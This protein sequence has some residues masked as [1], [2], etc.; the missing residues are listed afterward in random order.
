MSERKCPVCGRP[1]GSFTQ[2]LL[3]AYS[4]RD[5]LAARVAE[6]EADCE[7]LRVQ[8]AACGVAA[9]ENAD[10]RLSKRITPENPYWS[11]SYEDVCTAVDREVS[12]RSALAAAKAENERLRK[13]IPNDTYDNRIWPND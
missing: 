7:K 1:H 12:H 8:L 13:L 9:L 11:A 5:R 2:N 10:D 6:L 4:E 3:D